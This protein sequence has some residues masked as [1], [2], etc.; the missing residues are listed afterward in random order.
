MS[1][2]KSLEKRVKA[3]EAELDKL[4]GKMF[5]LD[6][7]V[8]NR[9]STIFNQLNQVTAVLDFHAHP[10]TLMSSRPIFLEEQYRAAVEDAQAQAEGRMTA[11]AP[12]PE[13]EEEE[14]E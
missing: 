8:D 2:K 3:L 11:T 10:I 5:D 12:V 13:E 6:S 9:I 7:D 4:K 14:E 1:E